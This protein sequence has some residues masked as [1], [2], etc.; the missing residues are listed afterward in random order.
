MKILG[1]SRVELMLSPDDIHGAV[2]KFNDV[3]GSSLEPPHT[4]SNG[5]ILSTTDWDAKIELM[6]PAHAGSPLMARLEKKGKGGIGPL[7]WEVEDIDAAREHV[8]AKGY[9]IY[10]EF[11]G[12]GVKQ[13]CLDPEEF[14]GYVITFMQRT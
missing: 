14:Y 1:F 4:V 12:E 11:E 9:S 5:D 8:L 6:G 13:I 2:E 3:L 10:Y 7:V